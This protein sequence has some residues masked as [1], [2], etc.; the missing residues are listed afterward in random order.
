MQDEKAHVPNQSESPGLPPRQLQMGRPQEASWELT[1]RQREGLQLACGDFLTLSLHIPHPSPA[2]EARLEIYRPHGERSCQRIPMLAPKGSSYFTG[3]LSELLPGRYV[4]AGQYSLDGQQWFWVRGSPLELHVFPRQVKGLRMYTWIPNAQGPLSEWTGRLKDIAE[5]GF[6]MIHILPI[7]LQGAS[8]SPYAARE[9]FA[10]EPSLVRPGEDAHASWHDFVAEAQKLGLGLCLDLV[11]NHVAIDSVLVEHCPHWIQADEDEEDGFRRAGFEGPEGWQSWQ[12]LVLL[13]YE[14]PDPKTRAEIWAYMQAYATHWA[15]FAAI[16]GGMLRL[17]NLHSTPPDFASTLTR[18]IRSSYPQVA[19]LGEYFGQ[20][21]KAAELMRS[22]EMDLLL[23]TPWEHHFAHELRS[24]LSYLQAS[25]GR[26]AWFCPINSHDS[27]PPAQEFASVASTLPRY[28]LCAGLGTGATGLTQG[29]ERGLLK[30]INFIGRQA[31][32][33]CDPHADF[34]ESIRTIHQLLAREPAFQQGSRLR[35]VDQNHNAVIA[36]LRWHPEDPE[37][38]IFL[39]IANLDI[40]QAQTVT[41]AS[42]EIRPNERTLFDLISG[43]QFLCDSHPLE[44]SLEACG[45]RLFAV[46]KKL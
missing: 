20:E 1:P 46:R 24:Y 25:Q 33:I 37:Q 13:H 2:A 11:V 41:I 22:C 30:K 4:L 43:T 17:D 44:I 18:S 19:L 28:L 42:E 15:Q 40:F 35:F 45:I 5:L 14:H 36:A 23:A 7:T 34:R 32:V 31:E 12:D 29:V 16:T 9:L 21:E 10:F 8:Q 6:T 27:G 38:H 26:L 39:L 3:T